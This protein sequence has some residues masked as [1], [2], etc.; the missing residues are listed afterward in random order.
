[1]LKLERKVIVLLVVVLCS[2]VSCSDIIIKDPPT[3]RGRGTAVNPLG[4]GEVRITTEPEGAKIMLISMGS[5]Q[6]QTFYS[7]ANINYMVTPA[8]PTVV[9]IAKKGYKPKNVRL[10]GTKQEIHVILEKTLLM[11]TMDFG[12]GA[13]GFGSGPGAGRPS[14]VGMGDGGMGPGQDMMPQDQGV[15]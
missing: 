15:K 9:T 7:P 13:G 14:D 3:T 6:M 11:P 2:M 8:M 10:D 4:M 12:G 1:M 5:R